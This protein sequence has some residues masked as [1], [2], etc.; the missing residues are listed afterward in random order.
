MEFPKTEDGYF[1]AEE[2]R[3]RSRFSVTEK[4]DCIE[5]RYEAEHEVEVRGDE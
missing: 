2:F 3:K 5:L 4:E 1:M